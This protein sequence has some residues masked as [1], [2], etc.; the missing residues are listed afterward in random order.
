MKII[1]CVQG[2]ERW[3]RA[4]LGI[5]TASCFDKILTPGGK[6][7]SSADHYMH[8]LIAERILGVP[9]ND[10]ATKWMERGKEME[11][12]AVAWYELERDVDTQRVGFCTTDDGRIGASPDRLVG[13]NGGL[14]VKTPTAAIHVGYLLDD[15]PNKYKP[16]VQGCMYVTGRDWWSILS[17]N[18][19]LPP[20]LV[21]VE[22]DDQFIALL[23][24][25]LDEFCERLDAGER[26]VREM[27]TVRGAA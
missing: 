22:R 20:A 17:Y 26:R 6:L 10:E 7:S 8:E 16:Q 13:T 18:P 19:E 24:V 2:D 14:E 21:T 11:P 12:Q 4:R 23:E 9:V 1:E 25:A 27:L 15:I 5:P 3:H